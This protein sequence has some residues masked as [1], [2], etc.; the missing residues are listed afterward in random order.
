MGGDDTAK[1]AKM[2]G[3]HDSEKRNMVDLHTKELKA[4]LEEYSK[5]E[6]QLNK[7]KEELRAAKDKEIDELKAQ[8]EAARLRY[9]LEI[10]ALKKRID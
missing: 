1:L 10:N 4:R 9:E 7:E 8:M 3:I 6:L 5:G 2:Q